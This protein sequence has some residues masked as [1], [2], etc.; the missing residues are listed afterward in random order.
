MVK[1]SE[2]V[3]LGASALM[4]AWRGKSNAFFWNSL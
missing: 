1:G 3:A 4:G 2:T